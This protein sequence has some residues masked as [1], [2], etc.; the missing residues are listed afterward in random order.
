[1]GCVCCRAIGC[2]SCVRLEAEWEAEFKSHP[3]I[4]FLHNAKPGKLRRLWPF[5]HRKGASLRSLTLTHC[6]LSDLGLERL[7]GSLDHCKQLRKLHLEFDGIAALDTIQLAPVLA[8]LVDLEVLSLRGNPI[9]EEGSLVLFEQV[10]PT[11]RKLRVLDLAITQ[12]GDRGC[13]GLL[14]VF[15]CFE[16][17]RQLSILRNEGIT[18]TGL[19]S[20]AKILD[21]MPLLQKI[22]LGGLCMLGEDSF[23]LLEALSSKPEL[24]LLELH[25]CDLE[26]LHIPLLVNIMRDSPGLQLLDIGGGNHFSLEGCRQLAN[27]IKELPSLS[28]V[29]MNGM[30]QEALGLKPHTS[31]PTDS[32]ALEYARGL[33]IAV[34][35]TSQRALRRHRVLHEPDPTHAKRY[36]ATPPS[37]DTLSMEE[38]SDAENGNPEASKCVTEG[39]PPPA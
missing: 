18:A 29:R 28:S 11:L 27:S 34:P 3:E 33:G 22:H 5:L 37:E 24:V 14:D 15:H 31:L 30:L 17:M 7:K 38:V 23:P 10:F 25:D 13:Q 8:N 20:V 1:M 21:K 2:H 26:D 12:L 35:R 16:D 6:D 19:R 9:G 32:A 39:S 36:Q 4:F